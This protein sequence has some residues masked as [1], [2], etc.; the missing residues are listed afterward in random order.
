[1]L[2][3]DAGS[4][5]AEV[6]GDA[7]FALSEILDRLADDAAADTHRYDAEAL[8][9]FTVTLAPGAGLPKESPRARRVT[10]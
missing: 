1:M 6:H 8:A 3:P 9:E 2:F 5:T 4:P 7:R 10:R